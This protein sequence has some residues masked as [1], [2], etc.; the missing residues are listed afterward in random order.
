M[1]ALFFFRIIVSLFWA[2]AYP[3]LLSHILNEI[4]KIWI[5]IQPLNYIISKLWT[6]KAILID[7]SSY[8]K[9]NSTKLNHHGFKKQWHYWTGNNSVALKARAGSRPRPYPPRSGSKTLTLPICEVENIVKPL[10]GE[11]NSCLNYCKSKIAT[12]LLWGNNTFQS[13]LWAWDLWEER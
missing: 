8:F 4:C 5:Q 6:F 13:L 9:R 3:F 2:P 11:N 10:D 12:L 1:C 7:C